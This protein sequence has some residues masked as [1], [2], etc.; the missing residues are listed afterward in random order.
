MDKKENTGL[1][2]SQI[3]DEVNSIYSSCVADGLSDAQIREAASVLLKRNSGR[4]RLLWFG[5][6]AILSA[7]LVFLCSR[8][9][10]TQ[11]L[12]MYGRIALIAVSDFSYSS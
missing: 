7:M 6:L 5:K 12:C 9:C 8:D 1:T 10:V 2:L 11:R 4:G 3:E